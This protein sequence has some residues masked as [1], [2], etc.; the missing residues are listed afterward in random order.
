MKWYLIVVL[1]YLSP[2]TY[3]VSCLCLLFNYTFVKCL[4]HFKFFV[5]REGLLLFLS[6][7]QLQ[8]FSFKFCMKTTI[9]ILCIF[10]NLEMI[11]PP[12]LNSFYLLFQSVYMWINSG[13]SVLCSLLIRIIYI[14]AI[15]LALLSKSF[16]LDVVSLFSLCSMAFTIFTSISLDVNYF[17]WQKEKSLWDF[18]LVWM[19]IW[20]STFL[21]VSSLSALNH[22]YNY[23][24]L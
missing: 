6:F 9:G 20:G 7:H 3:D 10:S 2:V 24:F 23:A 22:T 11:P 17:T 15:P 14:L 13:L 1:I 21:L 16:K 18:N 19:S 8:M 5:W 12:T 4:P